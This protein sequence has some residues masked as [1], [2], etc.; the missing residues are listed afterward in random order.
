[1]ATPLANVM[2]K[3]SSGAFLPTHAGRLVRECAA[4]ALAPDATRRRPGNRAHVRGG[5]RLQ[6][7]VQVRE[8][9]VPFLAQFQTASGLVLTYAELRSVAAV[10]DGDAKR[11]R[12]SAP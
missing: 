8:A 6:V 1:M 11:A 4:L 5:K 12:L 3:S 10:G 2:L 9:S 7:C